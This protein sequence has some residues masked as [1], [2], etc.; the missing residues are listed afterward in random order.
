MSRRCCARRGHGRG[1]RGWTSPRRFR[2][3]RCFGG[4]KGCGDWG[5]GR[6]DSPPANGGGGVSGVGK[7][8]WT[9]EVRGG[10]GAKGVSWE[11]AKG[12]LEVEALRGKARKGPGLEG[13]DLAK[14]VSCRQMLRW[15][16]GLWRLG[17]GYEGS[18]S[19]LREGLGEG[20]H[21]VAIDYGSKRNI[22]RNLAD[23]GARVTVLPE[24]GRAHV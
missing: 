17:Q 19:R 16:Q 21:V 5:R 23:A 24:I 20:P 6:R 13:R 1:W 18:P 3:G 11:N 15:S 10:G 7:R 22:F 4:R 12:E 14:E 8:V 2:A 9:G